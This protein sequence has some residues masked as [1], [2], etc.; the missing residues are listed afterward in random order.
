MVTATPQ[1]RFEAMRPSEEKASVRSGLLDT[2]EQRPNPRLGPATFVHETQGKSVN[3]SNTLNPL[4]FSPDL[5]SVP[6]SHGGY[7]MELGF[8][9]RK[10]NAR[11]FVC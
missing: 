5:A 7:E 3:S 2:P 9:A 8:I 1:V 6:W 4:C 10:S 11:V